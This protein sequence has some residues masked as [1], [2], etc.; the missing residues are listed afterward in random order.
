MFGECHGHIFMDGINFRQASGQ[1]RPVPCES[2]V[3]RKLAEYAQAGVDFF[4]D[5]GDRL[6][7]SRL[8]KQLAPEYGIDY[9]TPVFAI[10]KTRHYGGIVGCGFETGGEYEAL[11]DIVREQGGDFIKIMVS[12]LVD[13]N[14]EKELTED[15]LDEETIRFM[16]E[17]AHEKGFAVMAHVNGAD[18]VA[19]AAAAGADS[20]EHGNFSDEESLEVMLDHHVIWVPTLSAIA[21]LRASDRYPAAVIEKLV[22]KQAD[23]IRRGWDMG[24]T[25]ALGSDA[26]AYRVP[27]VFG[28]ED[29]YHL[30]CGIL[31]DRKDLDE[32]LMKAQAE[33]AKRFCKK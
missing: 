18:A 27:H 24:L 6:G 26:G 13:F 32:R 14:G 1:H 17:T 20:I 8:A 2:D 23:R 28:I 9:R 11:I 12:G 7:V 30:F 19:A 29:E 21:N 4:R 31:G 22:E 5:G 16:I 25:I 15:S 10:H 3:R 33:I